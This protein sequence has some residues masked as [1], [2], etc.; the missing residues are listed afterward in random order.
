M[1][2]GMEPIGID[3]DRFLGGRLQEQGKGFGAVIQKKER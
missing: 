1:D 3:D 2:K